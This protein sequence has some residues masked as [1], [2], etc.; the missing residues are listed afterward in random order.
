MN[1]SKHPTDDSIL[2]N[3]HRNLCEELH[4]SLWFELS[5]CTCMLYSTCVVYILYAVYLYMCDLIVVQKK[6]Q[7]LWST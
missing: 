6:G 7:N 1:Q 4:T 5:Y 3:G 2:Q